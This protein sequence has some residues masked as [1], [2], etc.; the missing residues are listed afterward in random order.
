M[1]DID[2]GK[3]AEP[4]AGERITRCGDG[5]GAKTGADGDPGRQLRTGQSEDQG[6]IRWHISLQGARLSRVS[7]HRSGLR[8]D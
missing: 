6:L 8:G 3:S 5:R 7:G 1:R 2:G 4:G